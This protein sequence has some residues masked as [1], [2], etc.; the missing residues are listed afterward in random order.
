MRPIFVRFLI[1]LMLCG[2]ALAGTSHAEAAAAHAAAVEIK[3]PKGAFGQVPLQTMDDGATY[4][5]AERLARLLKGSWAVKGKT[6]TLTVARRSAQFSRDQSRLTLQGHPLV[7][8]VAPRVTSKGW[9]IPADFL[10]KGLGRLVPG[11]SAVR[12]AVAS[13]KPSIKRVDSSVAFEEMRFRSYPSLRGSS[14]KRLP[15]SRTSRR[16]ARPGSV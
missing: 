3:G 9:L 16:P 2:A 1:S 12:P 4:V 6:G 5:A 7:L 13:A 8:E 14:S 15:A 10:D 11:V